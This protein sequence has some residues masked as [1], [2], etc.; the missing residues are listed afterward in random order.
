M[1]ND[2]SDKV[3]ALILSALMVLSIMV[4]GVAFSGTAAATTEN[5]TIDPG[6]DQTNTTVTHT[7]GFNVTVKSDDAAADNVTI[8]FGTGTSNAPAASYPVTDASLDVTNSSGTTIIEDTGAITGTD[9]VSVTFTS[10]NPSTGSP[11]SESV[12]INGTITVDYSENSDGSLVGDADNI[13][14]NVRTDDSDDGTEDAFDAAI[15]SLGAID[16]TQTRTTNGGDYDTADASGTVLP[17]AVV[18]QGEEGIT[19]GGTLSSTLSGVS[20]DSDGQVLS[21]PISQEQ[22]LGR[23]SNDGGEDSPSVTVDRPRITS[24]DVNVNGEDI[25]GGSI[26]KANADLTVVAESNFAQAEDLEISVEEESGLDITDDVVANAQ[27]Q[28]GAASFDVDLSTE[29][30]GTYT[31][32]VEGTDDLDFGAASETTTVDVTAQDNVGIE[33]DSDTVTQGDN[34]RFEI[35]GGL[36]GDQHLVQ[37]SD[38]DFRSGVDNSTLNSIF[39]NVEDVDEKGLIVEDGSGN[40]FLAE[41]STER[42]SRTIVGAYALVTIDDDTGLGVGSVDT[43]GLDTVSVGIDVSDPVTTGSTDGVGAIENSSTTFSTDEVTDDVDLDVEE[44]A[45][46]LDSPGNTYVVGS[47]IDVNGTASTGLDNVAIYVRDE[48]DFEHVEIDGS[49]TISVDADGTFEET[50]V[51]LSTSDDNFAGDGNAIMSLPGSYR[52]GVIDSSDANID[53]SGGD[54]NAGGPDGTLTTQ[55]FNQG[56]STQTSIR[57]IGGSLDAEFPSLVNGQISEDDGDVNVAGSAPGSQDVLFIAVGPRG[58]V[59]TQEIGV[60]SDT[61]FDE[62]DVTLPAR[63]SKGAISLHVYSLGRDD[64]VGDGELPSVSS[65]AGLGDFDNFV[66]N[67][68]GDSLTGDQVRSS[69]VSE[70][71]EDSATDDQ[72]VNQNARLVDTQSRIVNVY[73]SGNQASG[74]NPVAAGETLVLEGQT[75]LQPDDNTITV[76]LATEDVSVGLSATDEWGQ[77][78]QF[79][80]EIDTTDAATGTYTLDIDDGQNSVT[81]DVELVEEVSTATPTPTEADDTPTATASPTPTATASPTA[82]EMPDTDTSTPTEGGGPGFG[83]VVALVALLAAAL[84]ATR[85]D[86]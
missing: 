35:T 21:P 6:G 41:D 8:E 20:G 43:T 32:I 66:N 49:A 1:T 79:S 23:Y 4:G 29:D 65:G 3:R 16:A 82:T 56:T 61:T 63:I 7:V 59:F 69:I 48:G 44:G 33:V 10:E 11:A 37:I 83:A 78:G 25:S 73:Q 17:G 77:D 9:N 45:I 68:Q 67:L 51:V 47:D 72:L 22:T 86:N 76:E 40:T 28:S 85:R 84:L 55:E 70:T 15:F 60:D 64:R 38:S 62:E 27:V 50:D 71:I 13:Q 34:A 36:V 12:Q 24:F 52:I 57:T 46:T 18:F 5:E 74:I 26:G 19:F 53:T 81:E 31:I 80:V 58:N 75:N 54:S 42:D 39:R 2:R 14:A 30:A